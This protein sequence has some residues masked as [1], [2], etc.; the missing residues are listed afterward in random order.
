[1]L[2]RLRLRYQLSQVRQGETPTDSLD[3]RTLSPIDR[4][5]VAQAVREIT[6]VQRR[7][8][9]IA[10]NVPAELWIAPEKP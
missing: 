2:Q 1:V 3:R 8:D 9:G 5:V 6:V 4:T 10:N 7:M